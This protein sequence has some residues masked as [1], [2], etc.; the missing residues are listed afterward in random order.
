MFHDLSFSRRTTTEI[1]KRVVCVPHVADVLGGDVYRACF[2]FLVDQ[3]VARR[4]NWREFVTAVRPI[5]V[6]VEI[7][8]DGACLTGRLAFKT[9]EADPSSFLRDPFS[10]F[11]GLA[12]TE[13]WTRLTVGSLTTMYELRSLFLALC[14]KRFFASSF[15]N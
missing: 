15:E 3:L 13:A 2:I 1:R 7:L 9:S 5:Y 8:T 12:M 14:G 10:R 11:D 6:C 4:N